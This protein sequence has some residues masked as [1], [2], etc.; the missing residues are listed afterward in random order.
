MVP[1]DSPSSVNLKYGG[2]FL[3]GIHFIR[4]IE[5]YFK[6]VRQKDSAPI[7]INDNQLVSQP[8]SRSDSQEEPETE[9]ESKS[10]YVSVNRVRIDLSYL[11][12]DPGLQP[13]ISDYDPNDQDVVRRAYLLKVLDEV[14]VDANGSKEKGDA[15]ILL[16]SMRSFEFAFNLHLMKDILKISN[17]LSKA[18]QRKDQDIVNATT[19][20]KLSKQRLQ[21]FRDSGWPSFLEEVNSFF[22]KHGIS[23]IQMDDDYVPPGRSRRYGQLVRLAEFYPDDFSEQERIDLENHLGVYEMDMKSNDAFK[24]LNGISSLAKKMVETGKDVVYNLVYK[25]IKLSLISPVATATVERVFS[26]MNIVKSR[27]RNQM[28]DEW[29]NDCLITYIEKAIFNTVGDEV[30]MKRFQKMKNRKGQS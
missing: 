14:L 11:P 4:C 23:V 21:K 7:L 24:E 29:L 20:V 22:H 10:R 19:L 5:R 27:L 25:F 1:N 17:D 8:E 26:A 13:K 18:L 16:D 12:S 28:G 2:D 3:L 30:I 15:L 9:T 6:K